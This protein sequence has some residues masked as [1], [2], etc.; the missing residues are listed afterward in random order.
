MTTPTPRRTRRRSLAIALVTVIAVAAGT[1]AF[2][3]WRSVPDRRT[4]LLVDTSASGPDDSFGAV[5]FAVRSVAGN[6]ADRDAL[7]LRRFGG[8]CGDPRSTSQLVR[9]G[10]GQ[11]RSIGA[12]IS[13]LTPSGLATLRDG[14]LAAIDD[15]SG[16]YPFRA[17]TSN[18]IVVVTR[19]GVDA[20]TQEQAAMIKEVR[21]KLNSSSVRLE[22]R[23]V[24]YRIPAGKNANTLS[25]LAKATGAPEPRLVSTAADLTKTL[26]EL[27][28]PPPPTQALPVDV[29]SAGGPASSVGPPPDRREWPFVIALT[30]EWGV[31]VAGAPVPCHKDTGLRGPEQCAITVHEGDRFTLVATATGPDPH[32]EA[33]RNNPYYRSDNTLYWYGCDNGPRVKTRCTVTITRERVETSLRWIK[34]GSN[35][36]TGRVASQLIACVTTADIGSAP[37]ADTC[38]LMTGASPP[39]MPV[40]TFADGSTNGGG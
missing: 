34:G 7:A 10:I 35:S 1:T 24:G 17:R 39:P 40:V 20:C 19:T 14:I 25:Q 9:S 32:Q 12:A 23:F 26:T 37:E 29:P 5:A 2:V 38:A 30:T 13:A 15:F 31:T 4:T 21:N 22:F 3:L 11:G 33:L 16:A 18:R 6:A 36:P 8:H 27:T 28:I